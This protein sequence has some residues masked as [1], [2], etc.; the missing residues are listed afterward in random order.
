MRYSTSITTQPG[1]WTEFVHLDERVSEK[2]LS[3]GT[4]ASFEPESTSPGET[5]GGRQKGGMLTQN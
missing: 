5:A 3:L 4:A 1:S 2:G